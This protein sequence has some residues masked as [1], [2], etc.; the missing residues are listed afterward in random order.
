MGKVCGA[1]P[2]RRH[3]MSVHTGR[4]TSRTVP[5]SATREIVKIYKIIVARQRGLVDNVGAVGGR[6]EDI[7]P[8]QQHIMNRTS[9]FGARNA[10]RGIG[11]PDGARRCFA[12]SRGAHPDTAPESEQ[13]E[14][15][16]YAASTLTNP[17]ANAFAIVG[18][19][20][21]RPQG[22]VPGT[23]SGCARSRG[24][25]ALQVGVLSLKVMVL[26]AWVGTGQTALSEREPCR[27][28]EAVLMRKSNRCKSL[29]SRLGGFQLM[30]EYVQVID[31]K[32]FILKIFAPTQVV[33]LSWVATIFG[34]FSTISQV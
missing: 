12:E 20:L 31:I 7:G 3:V 34:D 8:E 5:H 21:K 18:N 14:R 32:R 27:E 24:T 13:Q 1:L 19:T 15:G 26:E 9:E 17:Q 30:A 16:V 33:D 11:K 23:V 10:K 25:S 29:I 2:R 4:A 6:P 22:R 28:R